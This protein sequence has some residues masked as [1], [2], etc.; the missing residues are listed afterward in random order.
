MNE[1]L[2]KYINFFKKP[3]SL[4]IIGAVGILL[5]AVS[6]LMPAKSN[7]KEVKKNE[8]FSVESYKKELEEDIN[9]VVKNIT[10][11]RKATVV[12]TLENS[13]K[14]SYADI[15]EESNS[16][17]N[18]SLSENELKQGYITV[19]KSDGSEEALLITAQMPD[20]KGVAIVC[21][22]GDNELLNEKIVNA[23]TAALN[24]TS[25][26]VYICGRKS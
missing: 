8:E 6:S 9:E 25:K 21:E 5:I 17:K 4:I 1:R 12:I 11:D 14:Y 3:K 7:E 16:Q 18:E 19:K 15:I 10:G 26:R 2:Y 22:G 20:I 24:I 13:V 23:V